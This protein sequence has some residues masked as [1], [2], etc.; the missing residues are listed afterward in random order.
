M[1]G[2]A[3][4]GAMAQELLEKAKKKY[5]IW[6]CSGIA[7]SR[8]T[9]VREHGGEPMSSLWLRS[10]ASGFGTGTEQ[11]LL[12]TVPLYDVNTVAIPQNCRWWIFVT[13]VN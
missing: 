1:R 2:I 3:H 7:V 13:I 4:V 5:Q 6:F 9:G 11:Q 8:H 12:A 10:T